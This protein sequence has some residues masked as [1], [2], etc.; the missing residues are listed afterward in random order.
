L[1]SR[2]DERP[3]TDRE[4]AMSAAAGRFVAAVAALGLHPEVRSF[5]QG[6]KTAEDA[7]RAIGCDVGQIVKSLVFVADDEP[8]LVLASGRNRVD[9]AKLAAA[10]GGG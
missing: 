3:G 4:A 9:V 10:W 5:P 1:Y 8:V 7:A 2:P 6:T